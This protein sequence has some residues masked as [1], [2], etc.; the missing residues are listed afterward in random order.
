MKVHFFFIG[1]VAIFCENTLSQQLS[2]AETLEGILTTLSGALNLAKNL[3]KTIESVRQFQLVEEINLVREI[4]DVVLSS[5]NATSLAIGNL[6]A[7]VDV[8]SNSAK[9]NAIA[10]IQSAEQSLALPVVQLQ[11]T[12]QEINDKGMTLA[13]NIRL[14][15]LEKTLR[16]SAAKVQS[17]VAKA[18]RVRFK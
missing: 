16:E 2:A 6:A 1:L 14:E 12:L 5:L 4:T 3:P 17:E 7:S 8:S 10:D 11:Q 15:L 13:L 9:M 18:D